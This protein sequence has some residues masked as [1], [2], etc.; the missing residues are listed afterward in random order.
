MSN[1]LNRG[2]S[3]S[4]ASAGLEDRSNT[5]SAFLPLDLTRLGFPQFGFALFRR[6]D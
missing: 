2:S 5:T 1:G 6:F 3:R 4:N